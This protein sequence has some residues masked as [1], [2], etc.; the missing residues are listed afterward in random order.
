MHLATP[1]LPLVFHLP[2][3]H[4][5]TSLILISQAPASAKIQAL[6]GHLIGS[7]RISNHILLLAV[8]SADHYFQKKPSMDIM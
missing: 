7:E 4:D 8:F 1:A 6:L 3:R 5:T 2:S